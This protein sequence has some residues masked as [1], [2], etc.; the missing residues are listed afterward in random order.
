[1]T[2]ITAARINNLQSRI[3]LILGSGAGQNGYGQA[4]ASKNVLT[5]TN[6]AIVTAQDLNNIYT[7]MINAR[8]HQVGPGD[9]GIAEVIQNLNVV[10]EDTSFFV[11]D[12]GV[13]QVDPDGD[14]K[15]LSDFESL[16]N[17]IEA[18][19][20][21]VH[22]SQS[23]IEDGESSVRTSVWNGLLVHEVSVNFDSEDQRRY[24]FNSGG[25]IWFTASNT[26]ASQPKGLDWA[27][28]CDQIGTIQF[29][30]TET[31]VT[32]GGGTSIGNYDLTGAFQTLYTKVGAGTYNLIYAG[33][34]YTLKARLDGGS[35]IIFRMEFND[36]AVDNRI[37]N[38]VDGRLESLV[39]Q[40]RATGDFVEV[41]SPSY[42]NTSTLA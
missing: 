7:D 31:A 6:N 12:A 28:L 17:F 32:S 29:S 41:N 3:E 27:E 40:K 19:K 8:V 39:R 36:V 10:A 35:R 18:D 2:D 15:G 5:G 26:G 14:D 9:V 1:M 33:N 38:N 42:F 21:E 13:T 4:I 11:T 22:P 37:D 24:F 30:A 34:V 25:E 23:E 20:F 16:M